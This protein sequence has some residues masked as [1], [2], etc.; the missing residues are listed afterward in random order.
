MS[1]IKVTFRFLLKNSLRGIGHVFKNPLYIL[2]AAAVGFSISGFIIWS[3]NFDLMRFIIFDAPIS[4]GEK[5]QLFWDVQTGIYTTYTSSQATGIIVFSWLFGINMALVT[6]VLK[7]GGFANIP[8]KS[9]GAGLVMALLSG[10]CVACG[11]SILAPLLATVGATS[12]AFVTSLSN[13][14][15]WIG[16]LLVIYSIFILGGVINNTKGSNKS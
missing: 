12:T 13:W 14:L 15:N 1:D 3:L 11:T 7:Y 5:L 6:Y 2:I 9:G 10:G 4:L 8:K 16:S